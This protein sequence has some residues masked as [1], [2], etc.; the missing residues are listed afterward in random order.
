MQ[1]AM[2]SLAGVEDSQGLF[3]AMFISMLTAL[4]LAE[5]RYAQKNEYDIVL[6][7]FF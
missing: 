6:E 1:Q 5:Q 3:S 4:A 7:R 2:G